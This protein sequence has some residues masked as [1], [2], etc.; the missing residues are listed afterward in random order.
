MSR[1]VAACRVFFKAQPRN[2]NAR[3]RSHKRSFGCLHAIYKTPVVSHVT[4]PRQHAGMSWDP[5]GFPR[6]L[7]WE[8]PWRVG[9]FRGGAYDISWH[10]LDVP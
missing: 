3:L 7:G 4:F 1:H 6:E 5:E 8:L 2:P 9:E 10:P